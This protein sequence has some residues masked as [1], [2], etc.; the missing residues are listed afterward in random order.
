ML[1][2]I[3]QQQARNA[4]IP[5]PGIVKNIELSNVSK[6]Q[7]IGQAFSLSNLITGATSYSWE[8]T[9]SN[10]GAAVA[11][12]TAP[13]PSFTI[14]TYGQYDIKCIAIGINSLERHFR[15]AITVLP[16][17]VDEASCDLVLDLTAMSDGSYN[18]T[19][20]RFDHTRASGAGFANVT[21]DFHGTIRNGFK[22]GV[23]GSFNG[24]FQIRN[25]VGDSTDE[26]TMVHF[27]ALE[28]C[29]LNATMDALPY[30]MQ[31]YGG[32]QHIIW[33]GASVN[34]EQYGFELTGNANVSGQCFFVT[35]SFNRNM[36]CTG[37]HMNGNRGTAT[38]GSSWQ[39]QA[40]HSA[41]C[42]ASNHDFERLWM[43]GNYIY[44][45][46]QE[47]AYFLYFTD[48][49]QTSGFR[50]YRCATAHFYHN[51]IIDAGRDGLQVASCDWLEIHDN[52]IDNIA[53]N[54]ESSHNAAISYNDGN[55]DAYIYRNIIK[56]APQFIAGQTGNT[57]GVM[58]AYCN[59][60]YQ[61]NPV[62]SIPNQ[63]SF[64]KI[65]DTNITADF[66]VF[67]NTIWC[68][69]IPYCLQHDNLPEDASIDFTLAGNAI[70]KG[71]ADESPWPE[72]RDL[73]VPA[74]TTA[75]LIDNSVVQLNESDSYY[76]ADPESGDF[77]IVGKTSPLFGAGFDIENRF[78]NL[79]GGY[80]DNQGFKLLVDRGVNG[81]N[82]TNGCFSGWQLWD[83]PDDQ[84]P[85]NLSTSEISV[86]SYGINLQIKD[87]KYTDK[88]AVVLPA[89]SVQPS[90][91]QIELG[92]DSNDIIG[93]TSG[94]ASGVLNTLQFV[95]LS[96]AN[97]YDIFS[98]GRAEN[99]QTT[100][101][102]K[103]TSTTGAAVPFTFYIGFIDPSNPVTGEQL[104]NY[105]NTIDNMS[106]PEVKLVN[107]VNNSN[108]GTGIQFELINDM[109]GGNSDG[110]SANTG[111][112]SDLNGEFPANAN[113]DSAW[114]QNI[115][116]YTPWFKL[117]GLPDGFTWSLIGWGSRNSSSGRNL[118]LQVNGEQGGSYDATD[119]TLY[120]NRYEANG[121]ASN[122]SNELIIDAYETNNNGYLCWIKVVGVPV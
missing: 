55:I 3:L 56:N 106:I 57:G 122:D 36:I 86:S 8:I 107:V 103:T 97:T 101:I 108:E 82:R 10:T 30:C 64:N 83:I 22:I 61:G 53:I 50:P 88:F 25:L 77:R 47:G 45:S 33:D 105:W 95:G 96:S 7:R 116:S 118:F 71:S 115:N 85:N 13:T 67:Y 76:L 63:F 81:I 87:D 109:S 28:K 89:G 121:V 98:F 54:N 52:Y 80:Y 41:T 17:V 65:E 91:A 62:A 111:Y 2:G 51:T 31:M 46:K 39:V 44:N 113:N 11:N 102:I 23:K 48:A 6:T 49:V 16:V 110:I 20:P 117:S 26:S 37:F 100:A 66:D 58:R 15:R 92:Q 59:Q 99:G 114:V 32:N 35:S 19:D 27:F 112:F 75:W 69:N 79:P 12:S 29:Y 4:L 84:A 94:T 72:L 104:G 120:S 73:G 18:H 40:T 119:N 90:H 9:D 24:H 42:N 5:T 1:L 34:N 14:N 43:Y 78:P 74:D 68:Q 93:I 60:F 21:L 70:M 38:G